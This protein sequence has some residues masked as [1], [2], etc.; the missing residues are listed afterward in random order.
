MSPRRRILTLVG[1]A[2]AAPVLALGIA[3]P[4]SAMHDSPAPVDEMAPAWSGHYSTPDIGQRAEARPW[5]AGPA[6]NR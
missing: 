2:V 5:Q 3:A 1:A 6:W 4:A